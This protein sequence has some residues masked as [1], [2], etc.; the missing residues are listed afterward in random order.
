MP[1][2]TDIL[3]RVKS[4]RSNKILS[5]NYYLIAGVKTTDI[6]IVSST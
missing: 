5:T 3:N 1:N 2:V 4:N 6:S